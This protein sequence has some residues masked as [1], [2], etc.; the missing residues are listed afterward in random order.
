MLLSYLPHLNTKKI[1]LASASPRRHEILSK[2]L[3]LK[4]EV[5][6]ERGLAG[7]NDAGELDD[8]IAHERAEKKCMLIT[9]NSYTCIHGCSWVML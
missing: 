2:Q 8:T 3:G 9:Y 5:R 6:M 1:V 4:F 7:G